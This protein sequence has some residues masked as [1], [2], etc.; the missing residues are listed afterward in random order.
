MK[1]PRQIQLRG[2]AL[3][4]LTVA[5]L[6]LGAIA[7]SGHWLWARWDRA[8][9]IRRE[10]QPPPEGM[11]FIP[12]GNFLM[13]SDDPK[14]DFDVPALREVFVPAYYIDRYEVTNRQY[15]KFKPD[16][17]YP[18]GE[19]EYPV[20]RV[21]KWDA[22]AYAEWAGKRLPTGAEWEKAARGE[23]GRIYPWG[24]EYDRT[25]CNLRPSPYTTVD[26]R[27][28]PDTE[29]CRRGGRKMAVGQFPAGV[30]PYGVH[31]LCGNAWEWVSDVHVPKIPFEPKESWHRTGIIRG[32]AHGYGTRHATTFHQ[33]FEPL[34]TTCNDVGFRCAKDALPIK[35]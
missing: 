9:L 34:N 22:E 10:Y 17:E 27:E 8:R 25:K 12:A 16:H 2:R 35:E 26:G 31:D 6:F 19:D 15:R 11:A 20:T 28:I 13:G 4:N 23:D 7:A 29:V 1:R 33:G 18:E 3:Q 30:S 32:G 5:I 21:L 24:N 14:A